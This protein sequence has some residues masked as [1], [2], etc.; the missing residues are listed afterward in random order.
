MHPDIPHRIAARLIA[1]ALACLMF[2]TRPLVA[3]SAAAGTLTGRVQDAAAGLSLEKARVVI[4]GTNREAF[5]DAFGEYRFSGLPAGQVTL[6]VSYTGLEPQT[7]T[8]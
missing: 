2:V 7:A 8:R 1:T 5:T 3:Q 6:R 4:V